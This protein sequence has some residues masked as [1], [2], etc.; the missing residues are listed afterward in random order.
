MAGALEQLTG[1]FLGLGSWEKL[2]LNSRMWLGRAGTP[3]GLLCS[4]FVPS[5]HMWAAEGSTVCVQP[6]R[7]SSHLCLH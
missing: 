3:R 7:D 5:S 6:F 4:V 1:C 2:R